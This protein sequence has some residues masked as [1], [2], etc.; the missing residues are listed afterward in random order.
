MVLVY[1]RRALLSI[2]QFAQIL[3]AF[4]MQNVHKRI[5]IARAE[6]GLSQKRIA[7]LLEISQ[8]GYQQIESGKNPEMKISTLYK[9][10]DILDVTPNYL[11][12]VDEK[13]LAVKGV[14]KAAT[15]KAAIRKV[16]KVEKP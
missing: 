1:I 13:A 5:K 6:K 8:P 11:L 16:A 15:G 14:K 7:E 4:F 12:G 10:C 3:G 9:L 2:W